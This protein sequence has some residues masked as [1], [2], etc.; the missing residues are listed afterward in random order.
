MK[1]FLA[2]LAFALWPLG[3]QAQTPGAQPEFCVTSPSQTANYN[4][5]CISASSSGG[6]IAVTNSGTATGG[7]NIAGGTSTGGNGTHILNLHPVISPAGT[8][9][10]T[11]ILDINGN[12]I[13]GTTASIFIAEAITL[14][15]ANTFTGTITNGYGIQFQAPSIGGTNPITTLTAFNVNP[16]ANGNGNTSGT[17]TN[18][19]FNASSFTAAAGI[20]GTI[21]N[22]GYEVNLPNGSSAGTNNYGIF[23]QGN[24][25]G[26]ANSNY[27]LYSSSTAPSVLSGSLT[28]STLTM[29]PTPSSL[30]KGI[31]VNQATSGSPGTNV[32]YNSITVSP[33]NATLSGFSAYGLDVVHAVGASATG[34][35]SAFKGEVDLT[36]AAT[37]GGDLIG[38]TFVSFATANNGGTDTG[39]GAV[40]TLFGCSCIAELGNGGTNWLIV[41]GAEL[42]A[43]ILTGGSSKIRFGLTI[44]SNGDLQGASSGAFDAGIG[45]YS[46]SSVGYQFGMQFTNL[47]GSN[48]PL[49]STATIF[50]TDGSSNTVA[51]FADFHTYTISTNIFN[52]ANFVVSGAGAVTAKGLPASAGSGGLYVC[53]DTNG[54]MYKKSA[55]P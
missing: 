16:I 38:G 18:I 2:L 6:Q 12:I 10:N 53:V 34:S 22:I 17:V 54:V 9:N 7:L 19:G 11:V 8:F 55:C 47:V 27:A 4:Q 49:S 28:I 20:G 43:I 29:N 50:G 51:N 45:F 3:A 42:Q 40:G 39:A 13:S 44:A 26:A 33:D 21:N 1:K 35:R 30:N 48:A 41:T 5:L 23:I 52:F 14:T 32:D 25:G 37:T 24:G 15:T 36:T 31:V 46:Y